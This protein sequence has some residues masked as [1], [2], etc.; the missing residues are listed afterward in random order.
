VAKAL[1]GDYR[2]EHVFALR[3]SLES[4]RYYQRLVAEVNQEIAFR[5]RGVETVT[6][7]PGHT[8]GADEKVA[9]A[10]PPLRTHLVRFAERT[11]SD[12]RCRFHGCA[13]PQRG[14]SHTILSEIGPD[15]VTVP[16]CI[17]IRLLV[18]LM[19][20]EANQRRQVLLTKNRR[21]RSRVA[22]ALRMA[23]NSLHHADNTLA[24]SFDA[25]PE[26]WASH[27]PSRSSLTNWRA[28]CSIC[29]A[30]KKLRPRTCLCDA[31]ERR[32]DVLNFG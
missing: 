31:K 27:R 7:G 3:Q 8:S 21:V 10:T 9:L 15:R 28:L 29:C 24:N 11:I 26:D 22:L 6:D 32:R 1:E 5:L 13:R 23:A 30:L 4:F 18:G 17:A 16:Q 20:G 25:L 2:E 12:L 19:P 14:D